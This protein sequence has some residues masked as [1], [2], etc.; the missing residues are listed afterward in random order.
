MT[1]YTFKSE[2]F[3]ETLEH[4]AKSSKPKTLGSMLEV[5]DEKSFAFVFFILLLLSALPIPTGGLTN[6]F[7]IIAMILALQMVVGRR[8]LWLPK[9]LRKKEVPKTVATNLLPHTIK[10]LRWLEKYSKT[11]GE[12]LMTLR[13]FRIQL[14]FFLFLFT[15]GA[16][17]APPFSFLDTLPS[18]GV[19]LASL[20]VILEDLYVVIL[21]YIVGFIGIA[22]IALLASGFINIIANLL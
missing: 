16:F 21:G 1:K 7:E 20:G 2:P 22:L 17:V 4:W 5:F 9:N 12:R 13:P 15:L 3:S 19:V 18:M 8:E 6:V 11:R 14:G 10:R